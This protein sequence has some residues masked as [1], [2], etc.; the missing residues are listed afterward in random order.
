V[1]CCLQGPQYASSE[2][3]EEP[4]VIKVLPRPK[5]VPDANHSAVLDTAGGYPTQVLLLSNLHG[6]HGS[7]YALLPP[8]LHRDTTAFIPV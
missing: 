7:S 4:I 6:Q 8:H 5:A 2:S 1:P 3:D